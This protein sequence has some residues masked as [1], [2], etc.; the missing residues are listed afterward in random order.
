MKEQQLKWETV[1]FASDSVLLD[2]F[3][4]KPQYFLIKIHLFK[5]KIPDKQNDFY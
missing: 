5:I 1:T 2:S 3:I 4:R